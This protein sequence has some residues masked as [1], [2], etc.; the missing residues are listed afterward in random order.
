MAKFMEELH[1]GFKP[2]GYMGDIKSW[3]LFKD[4]MKK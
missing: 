2:I 3:I 4:V 1:T